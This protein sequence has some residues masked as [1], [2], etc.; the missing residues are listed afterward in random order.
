MQKPN[1]TSLI[2][3][4]KYLVLSGNILFKVCFINLFI[5]QSF[6]ISKITLNGNYSAR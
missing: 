3:F 2:L 1:R 6:S 4:I 5:D